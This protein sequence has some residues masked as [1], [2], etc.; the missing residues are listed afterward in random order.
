MTETRRDKFPSPPISPLSE[1]TLVTVYEQVVVYPDTGI[2][3][4]ECLEVGEKGFPG[5]GAGI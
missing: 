2:F 4:R 1:K 5:F 3:G